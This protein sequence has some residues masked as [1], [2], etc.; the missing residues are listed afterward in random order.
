[1]ISISV[2]PT[3]PI[4]RRQLRQRLRRLGWSQNEL[5]RRIGRHPGYVSQV[6]QQKV[7][8]SVVWAAIHD[9]LTAAEA[10]AVASDADSGR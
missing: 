6:V 5:A 1:M 7:T 10:A 9:A 8:S 2:S 3:L 4:G